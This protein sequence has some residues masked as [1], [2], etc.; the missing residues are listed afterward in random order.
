MVYQLG[1]ASAKQSTGIRTHSTF[2]LVFPAVGYD[3]RHEPLRLATH[4]VLAA[5][6]AL[7]CV[8]AALGRRRHV[9][10]EADVDEHL[11]PCA[12]AGARS[13]RH[14]PAVGGE[15]ALTPGCGDGAP[16]ALLGRRGIVNAVLGTGALD[17]EARLRGQADFNW[18]GG[19]HVVQE[20]A[21][22]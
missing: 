3:D 14:M 19:G 9:R 4:K 18:L 8:L 17:A 10:V 16:G 20:K 13:A 21:K 6:R 11:Y 5:H 1:K 7:D 2:I 22:T 12:A 15:G